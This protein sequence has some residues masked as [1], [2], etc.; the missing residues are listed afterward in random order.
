[1][2]QAVTP[3]QHTSVCQRGSKNIA[4]LVSFGYVVKTPTSGNK[5]QHGTSKINTPQTCLP[6]DKALSILALSLGQYYFIAVD[7]I[8]RKTKRRDATVKYRPG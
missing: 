8:Q 5:I 2:S 3:N 6:A 7:G 4:S 1:M